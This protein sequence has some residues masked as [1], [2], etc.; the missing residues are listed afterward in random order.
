MNYDFIVTRSY[1][2][3]YYRSSMSVH[4]LNR[5]MG[6]FTC[7]YISPGKPS[8]V[9]READMVARATIFDLLFP[10]VLWIPQ[11]PRGKTFYF[12]INHMNDWAREHCRMTRTV[13]TKVAKASYACRP[14]NMC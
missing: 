5:N 11:L 14:T 13:S 6:N 9:Q 7:K 8:I 2:L 4:I 3:E 10:I 1:M 12:E